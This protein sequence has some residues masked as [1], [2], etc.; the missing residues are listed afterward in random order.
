MSGGSDREGSEGLKKIQVN[1][2]DPERYFLI[3]KI[4]A[5]HE[6]VELIQFLKEHVDVFA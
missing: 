3:G 6:E 1:E 2:D 5:K 4:L